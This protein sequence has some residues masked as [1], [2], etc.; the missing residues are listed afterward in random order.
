MTIKEVCDYDFRT[1]VRSALGYSDLLC[2]EMIEYQ[3]NNIECN[4]VRVAHIHTPKNFDEQCKLTKCWA[5]YLKIKKGI[6]YLVSI[7]MK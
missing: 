4:V 2:D 6:Y 7:G 3:L 5:G 1:M